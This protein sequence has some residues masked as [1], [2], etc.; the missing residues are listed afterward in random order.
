MRIIATVA[1]DIEMLDA[2]ETP[3]PDTPEETELRDAA[4]E[5]LRNALERAEQNGFNHSLS[6]VASVTLASIDY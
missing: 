3:L 2:T 6:N 5:A 1:L 4:K